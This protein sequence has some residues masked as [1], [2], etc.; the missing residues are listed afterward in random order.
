MTAEPQKQPETPGA[1]QLELINGNKMLG[2]IPP[3]ARH[4]I[5]NVKDAKKM[6]SKLIHAFQLGTLT[7]EPAKT[8]CYLIISYVSIIRDHEIEQRL[9]ALEKHNEEG[10]K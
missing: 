1:A 4:P 5:R 2:S 3:Y 6:L 9:A 8:L 7:S 10:A